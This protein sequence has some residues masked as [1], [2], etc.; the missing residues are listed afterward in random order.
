MLDQIERQPAKWSQKIK[1]RIEEISGWILSLNQK[2]SRH[3][4][5]AQ[6]D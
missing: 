6:P 1:A 3:A 2:S 4:P 5:V